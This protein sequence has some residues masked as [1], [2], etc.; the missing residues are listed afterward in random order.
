MPMRK[1][2]CSYWPVR[3]S[4]YEN[5]TFLKERWLSREGKTLAHQLDHESQRLTS[6][7]ERWAFEA[8]HLLFN[9]MPKLLTSRR[10]FYRISAVSDT[11][12]VCTVD[13]DDLAI[14]D[15]L[16]CPVGDVLD[17]FPHLANAPQFELLHQSQQEWNLL[18][19]GKTFKRGIDHEA[20]QYCNVLNRIVNDMRDK[21]RQNGLIRTIESAQRLA[22]SNIHSANEMISYGRE[23]RTRLLVVR[24]DLF[25]STLAEQHAMF[26]PD[27][28]AYLDWSDVPQ[29]CDR[30]VEQMKARKD[31][32]LA[33]VE[34]SVH[35]RG[36]LTVL[37]C[38]L[39]RGLHFH[40]LLLMDGSDHCNW[41]GI[42]HQIGKYW[43]DVV[44]QGMG[45]YYV[46]SDQEYMYR[47]VG[48]V[49]RLDVHADAGLQAVARY[50]GKIDWVMMHLH[51]DAGRCFFRSQ[52][53]R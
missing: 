2:T 26:Q 35:C 39:V 8:S 25:G 53:T 52:I 13:H 11:E 23:Q 1:I 14:H 41:V 43:R 47:C 49:E 5:D 6:A 22:R 20:Y 32:L 45:S 24:V 46:P 40:M 48:A 28:Y 50:F 31:R 51:P 17:V 18:G 33:Y 42:G 29:G 34:R 36:H 38:G 21:A 27:A 15:V 30:E 37:E 16:F 12:S 3:S 10:D 9:T 4:V 7:H 44:T 19:I